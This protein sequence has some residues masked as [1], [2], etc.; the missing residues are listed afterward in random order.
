MIK[1]PK[2]VFYEAGKEPVI[3]RVFRLIERYPSRSAAARAWGIRRTT[4]AGR[5][6]S[7]HLV[8]AN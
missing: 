8:L 5:I 3:E 4:T 2:G 6:Y 1:E 7:L